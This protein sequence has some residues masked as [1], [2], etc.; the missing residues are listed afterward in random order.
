MRVIILFILFNYGMA[1]ANAETNGLHPL[2]ERL[3]DSIR[4][5][6]GKIQSVEF[7]PDNTCELFITKRSISNETLRDFV[8]LYLYFFSKYYVLSEWRSEGDAFGSITYIM[9]KYKGYP[10]AKKS[11]IIMAQCLLRKLAK[12]HAIHLYFVRY[13][14][15][16]RHALLINIREATNIK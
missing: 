14:E 6:A 3:P 8:F 10:C 7:C 13:D 5:F 16:E 2:E 12:S 4:F 9:K 11:N 1:T 15:N